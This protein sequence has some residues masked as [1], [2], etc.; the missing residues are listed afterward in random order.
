MGGDLYVHLARSSSWTV[1]F[2]AAPLQPTT[3][4]CLL[5]G[6]FELLSPAC[7]VEPKSFGALGHLLAVPA[8]VDLGYNAYITTNVKHRIPDCVLLSGSHLLYSL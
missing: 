5:G 6:P 3:R 8:A 7:S 1:A 2:T 4:I